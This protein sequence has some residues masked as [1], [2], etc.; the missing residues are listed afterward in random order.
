M[1]FAGWL[2]VWFNRLANLNKS[3]PLHTYSNVT[4][5][6]WGKEKVGSLDLTP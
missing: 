4:I 3:S 2:I 6:A 1:A 5:G